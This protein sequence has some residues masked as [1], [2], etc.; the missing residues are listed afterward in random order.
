MQQLVCWEKVEG[1]TGF[2]AEVATSPRKEQ[3]LGT[4]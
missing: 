1:F 3:G 4:A 2:Q